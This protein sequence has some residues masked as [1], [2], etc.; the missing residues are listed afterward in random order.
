MQI[1]PSLSFI[2][3]LI[4]IQAACA[5]SDKYAYDID[6]VHQFVILGPFS[7]MALTRYVGVNIV[8]ILALIVLSAVMVHSVATFIRKRLPV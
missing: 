1:I 4:Q 5:L 7:L 2:D 6:L 8:L 3:I